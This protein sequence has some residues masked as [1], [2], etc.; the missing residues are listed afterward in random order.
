MVP[1][2][3]IMS[4]VLLH[5]DHARRLLGES[6]RTAVDAPTG[7]DHERVAGDHASLVAGQVQR[8]VGDVDRIGGHAERV[9]RA[10]VL[11]GDVDPGVVAGERSGRHGGS[12]WCRERWR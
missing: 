8:G 4:C 9:G 2:M 7:V 12:G 3:M 11:G 10:G 6:A 1:A 5:L